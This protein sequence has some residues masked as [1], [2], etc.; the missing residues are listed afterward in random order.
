MTV[1]TSGSGDP[2]RIS[3]RISSTDSPEKS[4]CSAC[5]RSV[6][7]RICEE[8]CVA[9][10]I[11]L[12]SL[13]KRFCLFVYEEA[14]R[15]WRVA[16]CSGGSFDFTSDGMPTT[17]GVRLRSGRMHHTTTLCLDAPCGFEAPPSN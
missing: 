16:S 15:L 9:T 12:P 13:S 1:S 8:D 11:E 10:S 2:A 17:H 4:A 14:D 7:G 3:F 5:L 6:F